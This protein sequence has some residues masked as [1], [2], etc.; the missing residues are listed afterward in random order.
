VLLFGTHQEEF[1]AVFAGDWSYLRPGLEL[2]LANCYFRVTTGHVT[3]RPKRPADAPLCSSSSM[4]LISKAFAP[5][6]ILAR[7]SATDPNQ[8]ESG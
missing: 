2:S 7:D 3:L 6:S 5:A 8:C 1:L 4:S